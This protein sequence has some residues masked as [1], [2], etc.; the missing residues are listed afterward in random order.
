MDRRRIAKLGGS[1]AAF[2]FATQFV[3][4]DVVFRGPVAWLRAPGSAL[5]AAESILLWSLALALATKR[6]RRVALAAVAALLARGAVAPLGAA[7]AL[8][9]AARGAVEMPPCALMLLVGAL[10]AARTARDERALWA[11]LARSRS[12][13]EEAGSS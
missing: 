8:A 3:W 6:S 13:R 4:L 9:L 12:D 2:S 5:A 7:V 1:I 10:A 11:S